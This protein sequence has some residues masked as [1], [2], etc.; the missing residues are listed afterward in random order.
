[1]ARPSG[2]AKG[3]CVSVIFLACEVLILLKFAILLPSG[4]N[5]FFGDE[6]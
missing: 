5:A 1:M 4:D 6:S 2:R 3:V